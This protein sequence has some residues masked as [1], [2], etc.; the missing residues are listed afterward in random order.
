MTIKNRTYRNMMTVIKKI[1]AKGWDFKESERMARRIFDQIEAWPEGL[2][3]QAQI[4]QILTREQW[5]AEN[6]F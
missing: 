2:S 5:E 1:Q 6:N 3:V 4:N